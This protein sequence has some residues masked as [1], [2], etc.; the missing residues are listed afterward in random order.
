MKF[1]GA[2]LLVAS[3]LLAGLAGA[4]R[5]KRRARLLLDLKTLLQA[6]QTGIRYAA[7]SLAGLVLE[8]QASRF[9]RLAERDSQFLSDPAGALERAGVALLQ[10][11]GDVEL[12]LGFV[13]GLGVSDT[14]G[15][16]EHI[17]LYR[18]LLEPRLEQ[19]RADAAQKSRVLVALGL[20]GGITLSLL[21]L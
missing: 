11:P 18:A 19:A 4:A 9:C 5:L 15:Q 1:L 7:E 14:Q 21:L 17:A 3:G 16:L 6:F 8:N 2:V 12:Y 20:F 10:E 13:R